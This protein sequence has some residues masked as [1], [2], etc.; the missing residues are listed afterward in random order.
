MDCKDARQ[1]LH[2]FIDRELDL[3]KSLEVEEHLKGCSACRAYFEEY[4]VLK[5][6]LQADSLYHRAPV[7][8][9]QSIRNSLG[10]STRILPRS[11][12]RS[13]K[14]WTLAA[15][16]IFAVLV[17]WRAGGIQFGQAKEEAVAQEV[18]DAH[19]RALMT[20]HLTDVLSTDKHTVKPWFDGKIDFSPEVPDLNPQGFILV[21]GRIDYLDARPTAVLVYKR[22]LHVINLFSCT[23]TASNPGTLRSVTRQGYH[24]LSWTSAGMDYWAVSDLDEKELREFVTNVSRL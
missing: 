11:L 8:L 3:L 14:T 18:L 19:I 4:S 13:W 7:R 2:A 20:N 23:A 21:G 1:L 15:S 24:V 22:R 17:V 16:F 10:L 5:T 9:Q 6:S 12:T